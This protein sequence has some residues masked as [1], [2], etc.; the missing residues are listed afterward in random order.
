MRKSFQKDE[1]TNGLEETTDQR[2]ADLQAEKIA[3]AK[4]AEDTKLLDM[5]TDMLHCELD[6]KGEKNFVHP[7]F[8]PQPSS[9][10]KHI[11]APRGHRA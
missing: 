11:S 7:I 6:R 1:V 2:D 8:T 5:V 4:T 3:P 10:G 9:L